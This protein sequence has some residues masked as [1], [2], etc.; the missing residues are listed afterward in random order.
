MPAQCAQAERGGT[1]EMPAPS[2]LLV[3]APTEV[4]LRAKTEHLSSE[5]TDLFLMELRRTLHILRSCPHH[6]FQERGLQADRWKCQ[7]VRHIG[8]QTRDTGS[9]PLLVPKREG[10]CLR[11]SS[12]SAS[13]GVCRCLAGPVCAEVP[14]TCFKSFLI[15]ATL[16]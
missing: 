7:A 15:T 1:A 13:S 2:G 12:W 8:N 16:F 3:E 9:L 4:L 14:A 6:C 5:I 10:S 11:N